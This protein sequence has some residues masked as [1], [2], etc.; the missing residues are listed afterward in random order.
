[1]KLMLIYIIFY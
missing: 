1:M